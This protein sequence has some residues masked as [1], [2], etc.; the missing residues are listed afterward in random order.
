MK[1]RRAL[2]IAAVVAA[3]SGFFVSDA[4]AKTVT[5][6]VSMLCYLIDISPPLPFGGPVS[7]SA[8]VDAPEI[9]D[10]NRSFQVRLTTN[11][12]TPLTTDAAWWELGDTGLQSPVIGPKTGFTTTVTPVQGATKV[13]Y[14]LT[15]L[16]W[17]PGTPSDGADFCCLNLSPTPMTFGTAVGSLPVETG[18]TDAERTRL[19]QMAAY[20]GQ[21]EAQTQITGVYLLAYL[22]GL[23]GVT[24]PTPVPPPPTDGA[25]RVTSSWTTT[26]FPT[27]QG[28]RDGYVLT[29]PQAQKLGFSFL[30]YVLALHAH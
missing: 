20:L 25:Y 23:E 4:G 8:T 11:T 16:D 30:S 1:A 18:Y 9:V 24:N 14:R 2:S 26:T 7:V 28:V 6:P 5:E 13:T 12:A 29:N 22:R 21:S 17:T 15:T 3:T 19:Q 27:L 10:A